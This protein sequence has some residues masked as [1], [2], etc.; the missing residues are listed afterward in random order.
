MITA[1]EAC[2]TVKENIEI[3]SN[4]FFKKLMMK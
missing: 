1:E 2:K 4:L 3:E